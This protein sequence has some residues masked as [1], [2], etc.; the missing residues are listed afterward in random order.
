MTTL[1]FECPEEG[2]DR[3]PGKLGQHPREVERWIIAGGTAAMPL[4]T[5]LCGGDPSLRGSWTVLKE[6]QR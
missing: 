2:A 4:V 5:L 3:G 1:N 6:G